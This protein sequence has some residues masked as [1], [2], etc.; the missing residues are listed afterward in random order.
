MVTNYY[1]YIILVYKY[2]NIYIYRHIWQKATEEHPPA[3]N[4]APQQ[5]SMRIAGPKSR[6]KTGERQKLK[7]W[8][9]HNYP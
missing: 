7:I 4:K 3:T 9:G 8:E 2:I 6:M 1:Q 5:L